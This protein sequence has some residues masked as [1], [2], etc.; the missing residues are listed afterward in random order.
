MSYEFGNTRIING[1]V[2]GVVMDN[3]DP[4]GRY[5]VKCKLP[6]IKSTD[7]GDDA[8]F[9]TS[10]CKVVTPMA[11]GGRGFYCLP[12]IGDEV[13]L[14]PI[15]GNIRQ[16]VVLG[17]VWS[18]VD[19]MPTGDNAPQ[20]T[21]DPDGNEFGVAAAAK[22]NKAANGENNARFMISRSGSSIVFDDTKG[23][24]KLAF[25]TK[26]G[27]AITI[28]D[29]KKV[30]SI[31]DKGKETYLLFDA[32]NK[33]IRLECTNGDIDIICKNGTFTLDAKKI[34]TKA[35]DNQEHKAGAAWK[36]ES[37]STMDF[38]AGGTLT[39]KAPKIDLNP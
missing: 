3:K 28:N 37:G 26:A 31:Y 33:K 4:R 39:E 27:S 34:V 19:K 14:A 22:D 17:S 30:L 25:F 6:W 8:D 20:E 13:V 9:V 2:W 15:H 11:G 36:Q 23:K 7:A 21:T 35:K 18:E 16:M 12:E 5:M 24:E 32:Q 38:K 29:E 10:W 1:V